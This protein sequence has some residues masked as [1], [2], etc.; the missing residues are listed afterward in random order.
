M[1]HSPRVPAELP[2]GIQLAYTAAEA[3]RLLSIS[4][5]TLKRLEERGLI[6]SSKALRTKLYS[7]RELERF[8]ESTL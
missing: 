2:D 1:S 6:R 7:H 3:S 4:T 8:L 5:R